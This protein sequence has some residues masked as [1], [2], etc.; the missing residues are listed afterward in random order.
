MAPGPSFISLSFVQ[1]QFSKGDIVRVTNIVEGG[2]WEGVCNGKVGWFP[3]NFVEEIAQGM[4]HLVGCDI[5]SSNRTHPWGVPVH[6]RML[7]PVGCYV[8]YYIQNSSIS[9]TFQT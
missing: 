3:G 2:W 8:C 7:Y 9:S 4:C 6:C 5:Y 1:L